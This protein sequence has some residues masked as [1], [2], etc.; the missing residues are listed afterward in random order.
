MNNQWREEIARREVSWQGPA[1]MAKWQQIIGDR[2]THRLAGVLFILGAGA[3]LLAW[4]LGLDEVQ[5]KAAWH[6]MENF[7]MERPW[8]LFVGLAVLP[9]FMVPTTALLILAG[10][11]WSD[12]PVTACAVSLVATTLNMSWTYWVAARPG[13]GL[14]EKLLAATAVQIPAL[15]LGNHLRMIL[16]VRLTPGVPLFLQNYVLGFFRVPFR[17]YLPVS[18]GCNG[19]FTIGV[20]LST[21]GVANG[22][23]LPL[24]SGVALVALG[25]VVVQWIKAK[26]LKR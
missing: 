8:L 5:L 21:A 3:A 1:A 12:H 16:I 15:P 4:R 25:L 26:I 6:G 18:I 13:R 20:V 19:L 9:G 2:R 23:V 11:V 22:N 10:T 14:A 17:L 7:L 24:L